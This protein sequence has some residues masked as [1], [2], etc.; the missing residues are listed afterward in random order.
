MLLLWRALND[1]V[2]RAAGYGI[3]VVRVDGN[4]IFAVYN[5]VKAAKQSA[6]TNNRYRCPVTARGVSLSLQTRADRGHDVPRG[7]PQHQ[8]RLQRIPRCVRMT[9]C[10]M[11]GMG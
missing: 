5:A 4:D 6:V 8:R 11:H 3:D 7:A 9:W 2:S 1:P 10:G